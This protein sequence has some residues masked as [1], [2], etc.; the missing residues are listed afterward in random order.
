[1]DAEAVSNSSAQWSHEAALSRCSALQPGSPQA[2][3][4]RSGTPLRGT[5][6]DA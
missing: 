3:R 5:G 1:V 4:W 6:L 2:I